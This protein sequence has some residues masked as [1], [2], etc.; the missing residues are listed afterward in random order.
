MSKLTFNLIGC[1][2]RN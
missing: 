1:I 2:V